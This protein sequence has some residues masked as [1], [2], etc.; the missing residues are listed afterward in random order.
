MSAYRFYLET[1]SEAMLLQHGHWPS[2]GEKDLKDIVMVS[3]N[4]L[5]LK[6]VTQVASCIALRV[7][8]LADNFLTKIEPLMECIHLIVQLPEASRWSELTELQLLYLHDNNM[9]TWSHVKGLSACLNLAA[10]TLWD[11]PLS[12]KKNYRHCLVNNVCSLKALDNFVIS[13]EEIIQNWSLPFRFKAMKQ[14]FCVGLYPSIKSDSFEAEM[15]AVCQI[16]AVINRIQAF[17]SPT[18]VIQRWIRGHLIRKH[19]GHCDTKKQTATWKKTI[20][21]THVEAEKEQVAPQPWKTVEDIHGPHKLVQKEASDVQI[22]RLH[23][24]LNKLMKTGNSEVLQEEDFAK[25]VGDR[26]E[27]KTS[28]LQTSLKSV[29]MITFDQDSS[30]CNGETNVLGLKAP[31]HQSTSVNDILLSRKA[32]GQYVPIFPNHPHPLSPTIPFAHHVIVHCNDVSLAPFKVIEKAHEVLE[33]SKRQRELVEKVTEHRVDREV[34]KVHRV[35]L[36]EDQRRTVRQREEREKAEMEKSLS[37]Q[38]NRRERDILEARQKHS[39]FMEEK[40]K[41]RQEREMVCSFSGHH[42]SL[43][44]AVFRYNRWKKQP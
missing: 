29:Q 2:E 8:V 4:N 37:I 22:K 18:L 32:A 39:Q 30:I 33:K 40:R 23:V 42:N 12:L 26:R 10:L 11:T 5:L 34:A 20:L 14:H 36:K 43:A 25:D 24:N 6:S 19:L 9:S 7:C 16:I 31:M 27:T 21:T 38:R 17:H 13:D 44:K 1:C 28:A 3:L 41:R 15:K 35:N